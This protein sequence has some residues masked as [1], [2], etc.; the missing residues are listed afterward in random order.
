MY[1]IGDILEKTIIGIELDDDGKKIIH[2]YGYSWYTGSEPEY[3]FAEYIFFYGNLVEVLE[4]G[5]Y[6]YEMQYQD[7]VKQYI[8]EHDQKEITILYC[9]YDNGNP[10]IPINE[11][12]ISINT[13]F[14]IYYVI[15]S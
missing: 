7:L 3:R 5:I 14:G 1:T 11:R 8:S 6:A 9:S 10:A 12:D 15:P 13:P 2:Y 4:T